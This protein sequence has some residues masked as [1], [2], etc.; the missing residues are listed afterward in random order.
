LNVEVEVVVMIAQ[1]KQAV[2]VT[3]E[4]PAVVGERRVVD[5]RVI[6]RAWGLRDRNVVSCGGLG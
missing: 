2:V 1:E 4:R 3:S 6:V 5:E